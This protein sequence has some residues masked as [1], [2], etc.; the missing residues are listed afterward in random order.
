MLSIFRLL[1]IPVF[2]VVYFL[3]P[4]QAWWAAI[5]VVVSGLTDVADGII[6]RKFNQV[7]QLGKILDPLAD[8]LTQ[9]SVVIA[10]CIHHRELIFLAV[11]F[12]LKELFMLI[13]GCVLVKSG[14][15]IQSAKWFG[16]AAT[17]VLYTVMFATIIL[18]LPSVAL[19]ILCGVAVCFVLFAF[20]MYIPEFMKQKKADSE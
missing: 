7:T 8:K 19:W 2:L 9:A 3:F 13:G 1:L 5:I 16:K 15:K 12:C 10:L 4:E 14:K 20:V 17:V 6:A 18:P 11:V